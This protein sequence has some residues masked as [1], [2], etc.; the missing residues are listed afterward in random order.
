M[1]LTF[2][3]R[4]DEV[5]EKILG[6]M[7]KALREGTLKVE[8]SRA[9][10]KFVLSKI[11]AVTTH[12]G[13]MELLEDLVK[14]WGIYESVLLELKSQKIQAEDNDEIKQVQAKLQKFL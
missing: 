9:S 8:E 6:C 7:I 12:Q 4:K 13:L 1:N 14:R 10:A 11:D 2:E 5:Q 3:D